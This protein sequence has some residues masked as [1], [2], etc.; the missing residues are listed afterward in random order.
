V[1]LFGDATPEQIAESG[2]KMVLDDHPLWFLMFAVVAALGMA[3]QF[4]VNKSYE[5]E[6]YN[7]WNAYSTP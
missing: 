6:H 1:F 2:A 7:R 4:Q 5:I 3:V